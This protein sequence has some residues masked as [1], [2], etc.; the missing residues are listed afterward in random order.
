[1]VKAFILLMVFESGAAST[2]V[3]DIEFSSRQACEAAKIA[4]Q[5]K[6]KQKSRVA[7]DGSKTEVLKL[8]EITCLEK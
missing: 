1:M 4:V 7:D 6:A 5:S 2:G 3:H 8:V